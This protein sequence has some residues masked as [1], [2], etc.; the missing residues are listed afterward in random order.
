VNRKEI[1]ES[2][3]LYVDAG[4]GTKKEHYRQALSAGEEGSLRG[5]TTR[6]SLPVPRRAQPIILERRRL[7]HDDLICIAQIVPTTTPSNQPAATVLMR[8]P[9][10][11]V[12]TVANPAQPFDALYFID[13]LNDLDLGGRLSHPSENPARAWSSGTNQNIQTA[14]APTMA[15]GAESG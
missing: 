7:E 8:L 10:Y 6:Q 1:E 2:T 9:K 13:T 5:G 3:G 11:K 4:I 14:M 12:E 15:L